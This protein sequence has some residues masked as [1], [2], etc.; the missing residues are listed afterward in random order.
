MLFPDEITTSLGPA[1]LIQPQSKKQR[2]LYSNTKQAKRHRHHLLPQNH[3]KTNHDQETAE[4][5]IAHHCPAGGG[6]LWKL[7]VQCRK[8]NCRY[9]TVEKSSGKRR[10]KLHELVLVRCPR[11]GLSAG[12]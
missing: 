11:L 2:V 6:D 7:F 4:E 3:T 5:H 1:V 12:A 8:F 9:L 10:L